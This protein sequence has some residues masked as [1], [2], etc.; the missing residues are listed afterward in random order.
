[1][2]DKVAF[3]LDG[4]EVLTYDRTQS[5]PDKQREYLDQL[6]E[7]LKQGF[8]LANEK[9]DKPNLQQKTQFIALNLV[10]ALS[11]EDDNNAIMMFSYLVNI[12]PDLKQAKAK[13]KETKV[14]QQVGVE[15]IF[16]EVKPAGQK[17]EFRPDS[18]KTKLH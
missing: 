11:K 12:M 6:D 2:S 5:L 18:S 15:F 3:L 14:G 16:D 17:I 13:L 9:I 4:E 8:V 10:H 7:Q 1:M